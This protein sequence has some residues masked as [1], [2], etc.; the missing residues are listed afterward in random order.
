MIAVVTEEMHGSDRHLTRIDCERALV[1]TGNC[2][3]TRA[4]WRALRSARSSML[5]KCLTPPT[6]SETRCY[7]NYRKSLAQPDFTR[8][9]S[10]AFQ[11]APPRR[12][13]RKP[14]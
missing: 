9:L 14:N 11:H 6:L 5:K 4:K 13:G 10:R 2:F 1:G 3:S 12:G 8:E 7:A